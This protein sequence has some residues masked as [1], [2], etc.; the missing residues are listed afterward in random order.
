LIHI[1]SLKGAAGVGP[2]ND[3]NTGI[4]PDNPGN[5]ENNALSDRR[6]MTLLLSGSGNHTGAATGI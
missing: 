6:F 4:R 1:D 3:A 2:L 5:T